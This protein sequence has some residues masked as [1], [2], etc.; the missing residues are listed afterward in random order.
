MLMTDSKSIEWTYGVVAFLDVLGFSS[1]VA[2]DAKSMTP[3]HLERIITALSEAKSSEHAKNLDVRAFSDSI[4]ISTD[5]NPKAIGD[6]FLAAIDL[7]RR[8]ITKGIL[9]RGGIAFGKHYGSSDAIYSEALIS[10]YELERDQ[11][12]FP[13]VLIDKNLFDW[14][15]N[16]ADTTTEISAQI[17]SCLLHDRDNRIFLSYLDES[18][19]STHKEMLYSY[20]TESVNASVL[21]KLQ[22]LASYHNYCA[23]RYGAEGLVNGSLVEPFRRV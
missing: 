1:F 20:R 10:A 12:R 15:K 13:R 5:L 22:W 7:Q 18:M 2:S 16:D 14:V 4:V 11:A 19:L 23:S 17:N 6:L 3:M 21:E 8:F 9:I